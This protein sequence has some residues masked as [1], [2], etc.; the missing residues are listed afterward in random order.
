MRVMIDLEH[1]KVLTA[2]AY[3]VLDKRA[4]PNELDAALFVADTVIEGAEVPEG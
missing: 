2:A 1:L 4:E 3:E